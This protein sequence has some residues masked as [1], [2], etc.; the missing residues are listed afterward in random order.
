[1]LRA[2][3]FSLHTVFDRRSGAAQEQQAAAGNCPGKLERK[4]A[5][6]PLL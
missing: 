6:A 2:G 4:E 1:L 5:L 3:E